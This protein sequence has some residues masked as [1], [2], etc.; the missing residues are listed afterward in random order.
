MTTIESRETTYNTAVK[1]AEYIGLDA[2]YIRNIGRSSLYITYNYNDVTYELRISDHCA[3]P[4]RERAKRYS[5][6]TPID[7][8]NNLIIALNTIKRQ[9]FGIKDIVNVGAIV[10][11]PKYG[12]GIVTH[13]DNEADRL[14]VDFSGIKKSF[15]ATVLID[16]GWI[17]DKS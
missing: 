8:G 3:N 7:L 2:S 12:L 16:R 13:H 5:S 17:N 10:N 9:I 14:D 1:V 6:I 11:H 4:R 15:F